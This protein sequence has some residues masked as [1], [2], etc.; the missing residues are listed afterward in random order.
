[1]KRLFHVMLT[2]ALAT[3]IL[4]VGFYT[5]EI[6]TKDADWRSREYNYGESNPRQFTEYTRFVVYY[7][8]G[9]LGVYLSFRLVKKEFL[10]NAYIISFSYLLLLG[11]HGGFSWG[12]HFKTKL[13]LNI[14]N[15]GIFTFIYIRF[16]K[17]Y[18]P[19]TEPVPSAE[20]PQV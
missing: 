17:K 5:C 16:I 19:A 4:G 6:L 14:L 11:A 7:S 15:T 10:L 2:L 3:S 1:M 12:T 8:L 13:F 9:L 18:Y 20:N